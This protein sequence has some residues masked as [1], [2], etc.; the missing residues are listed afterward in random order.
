M[1]PPP[2]NPQ[3][4]LAVSYLG[5]PLLVIAGA[6]SGKTGVITRKIAY[7]IQHA[8]YRANNVFAVTFTNKAAREMVERS[9]ALLGRQARGLTISTF[10]R[11]GLDIL[12]KEHSRVGLRK[13]FSIFDARDGI[14]LLR[15]LTKSEDE[16]QL[17]AVQSRIS[18]Y[19]NAN[20]DPAQAQQLA[21]DETS[22]LAARAY[23][24]YSE[25]LRAY[26]AVD[27]DD[28]LLI[29]VQLLKTQSDVREYW[30]NRVRYLLID[31]Y[32][33]TNDCQYQLM[34]L[35]TGASGA[36]T[37]VGD[38][39]QSIYA[40]RGAQPQNLVNLQND[41]PQLKTVK[42]EQNY[43]C[44][45]K[46][47]DA[48]NELIRHNPHIVEKRLWSTLDRGEGIT[49]ISA[50][51]EESEAESI[52][53]DIYAARVRHHGKA[54]DFAVLYRSNFQ[55]RVLE[56]ALRELNLPYK[57]SGGTGFYEHAEIRDL[58]SYLRLINNP[59]DDA[60]FLR[61]CNVPKR[62]IGATTLSKLGEYAASRHRPLALAAREVGLAQILNGRAYQA[63]QQFTNWL[64]LLQQ[65]AENLPPLEI[66]NRVI[67]DI[68]YD[69]H[70]YDLHKEP[71]KVE[72][73]KERI[74]QLKAWIGKLQEDERL[75]RLDAL[76][77]HLMLLDILD[78]QEK[79]VDAIQLM[80]LHAAKG[81]EF[82][83]VYI[84]G[85]EEGLLPHANSSETQE[86]LEEERRLLYVGM[87][88]AKENLTL[89]YTKQRRKGG[90]WQSSEPSRF[91]D[92]LPEKGINWQDGSREIDPEVEKQQVKNSL[93]A[94]YNLLTE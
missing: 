81:L 35:L 36:F 43:R 61:V 31:E 23:S 70:L 69:D 67:E 85:V 66:L 59:E 86:G 8:D 33:D 42:L 65:E 27:F 17:R 60:A 50:K 14:T 30:Q 2:L 49:V 89:S 54:K 22:L 71:R 15:E 28:L 80:T 40:W 94:L 39:D 29:P 41:Y 51:N 21:H 20:L 26:N 58:L 57:I 48:A 3:Q 46:I 84:I 47:L 72:K 10:H 77:Q 62:E 73:R 92:D 55:S 9:R 74:A 11:L 5:G 68:S 64:Q 63:L 6:G 32:Q 93:D 91:F 1:Q 78:K 16:V 82:P 87:T 83:H 53:R 56:Q 37:A 18:A 4:Q 52:A 25:R 38:D 7:L 19:K 79:D 76:M 12:H 75:N 44:H 34:Q 90:Q 45:K 88:R 13:G 24:I